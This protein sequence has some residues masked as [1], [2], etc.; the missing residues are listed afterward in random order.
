MTVHDFGAGE[1]LELALDAERQTVLVPFTCELV[2]EVR[3]ADGYVTVQ[4]TAD[5]VGDDTPLDQ[6]EADT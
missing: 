1:L 2:P 4:L 5:L 6:P 3:V